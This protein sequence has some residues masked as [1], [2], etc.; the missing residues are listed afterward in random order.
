MTELLQNGAFDASPLG[1]GWTEV[2][3]GA[4]PLITPN[5][6]TAAG[7]IDEQTAPNDAWLGGVVSITDILYQDVL[8]PPR[9]RLVNLSGFYEIRTFDTVSSPQDTGSFAWVTTA[10]LPI[11][12]IM[13]LDNTKR[14]TTWTTVNFGLANAAMYAGMMIRLQMTATNNASLPTSFF[15]DTLSVKATHCMP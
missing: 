9:T 2:P 13:T 10:N 1:T 12:T 4:L 7:G 5:G 8:I 6:G 14:T 3:G 15:F 11:A